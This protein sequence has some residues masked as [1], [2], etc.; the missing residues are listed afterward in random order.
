VSQRAYEAAQFVTVVAK[1]AISAARIPSGSIELILEGAGIEPA[2]LEIRWRRECLPYCILRR[3]Q[4]GPPPPYLRALR[5]ENSPRPFPVV[6][7]NPAPKVGPQL[8]LPMAPRTLHRLS[9]RNVQTVSEPGRH[10]DGG[11]LYLVVGRNGNRKWV[12]LF[13][14]RGGG[15]KTCEMGLGSFPNTSL[16]AARERAARARQLLSEGRDPLVAKRTPAACTGAPS[17]AEVLDM[18]IASRASSWRSAKH[19]QQWRNSVTQHAP[20]LM[21]RPVNEVDTNDVLKALE[22]IWSSKA[23]TASR[24]RSRI[25]NTLDYAKSKGFRDGDNPA[26]WR[27]HLQHVFPARRKLTRGHFASM[28]FTEVPAFVAEVRECGTVSALAMEVL[29]LCALRTSEVIGATWPEVDLDTST[30]TIPA[31]R[32]K[33]GVAFKVPLPPRAVA[34]FTEMAKVKCG[35]HVFR[36]N[37]PDGP[38]S[39]MALECLLRRMGAKPMTT[40]GFRSS[41]RTWAAEKTDYRREVAEACLAHAIADNAVEAAYLRTTLFDSRRNLLKDWQMFITSSPRK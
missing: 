17:F 12:F 11:N 22:P 39:N 15:V 23:E 7:P 21:Q 5:E 38:L 13:K 18:L 10:A 8:G 34:I 32:M 20:A 9:S 35:V 19:K 25:E 24:V 37:R 16:A 27:S 30:W 2:S 33:G 29:I 40:H 14:R 28:P 3:C 36:G 41:F 6:R 1:C 4:A 31:D 26:R